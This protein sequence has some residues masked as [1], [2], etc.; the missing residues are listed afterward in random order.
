M[1]PAGLVVRSNFRFPF[2]R[3]HKRLTRAT[4]QIHH[5]SVGLT[6]G[7]PILF[8]VVVS[9]KQT[10]TFGELS[11]A[12]QIRAAGSWRSAAAISGWRFSRGLAGYLRAVR[13]HRRAD[14]ARRTEILERRFTGSLR[15]AWRSAAAALPR[16][17]EILKGQVFRSFP[18]RAR[19]RRSDT[20]RRN[21]TALSNSSFTGNGT[22]PCAHGGSSA[23][24]SRARSFS[25]VTTV[26]ASRSAS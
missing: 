19:N 4:R 2:Q 6:G 7:H 16:R 10:E 23:A 8:M 22:I 13:G 11:G 14:T 9:K 21:L 5:K 17:A 24:P 18:S 26:S 12:E 15:A 25:V 1:G 20:K 3:H